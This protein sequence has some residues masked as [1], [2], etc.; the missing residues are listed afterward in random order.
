MGIPCYANSQAIHINPKAPL[1][2]HKFKG[3]ATET[4]YSPQNLSLRYVD[5][6][7]IVLYE[8]TLD[9]VS[10]YH[11]YPVSYTH[12]D[13]YKRQQLILRLL[14]AVINVVTFQMQSVRVITG[15]L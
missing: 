7:Y 9:D 3:T 11:K 5:D 13:V 15:K 6:E 1:M 12:L 2:K 10:V 14:C 4:S 8:E